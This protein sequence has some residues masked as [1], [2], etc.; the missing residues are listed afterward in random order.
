M[1]PLAVQGGG[2]TPLTA[3]GTVSA[4]T[5]L[6]ADGGREDNLDLLDLLREIQ[7]CRERA[8]VQRA[9]L[10]PTSATQSTSP[11]W[12]AGHVQYG[13]NRKEEH[14]DTARRKGWQEDGA[15]LMSTDGMEAWKSQGRGPGVVI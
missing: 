10:R 12:V 13:T 1:A 2:A 8:W 15:S 7:P 14:P 3:V 4:G 9:G 11:T 5:R 6:L